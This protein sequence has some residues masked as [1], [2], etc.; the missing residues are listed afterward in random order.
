MV[1]A[2]QAIAGLILGR[3]LMR[4]HPPQPL[5]H[6]AAARYVREIRQIGASLTRQVAPWV[7]VGVWLLIWLIVAV[8]QS[9]YN[10]AIL[11]SI[12]VGFVPALILSLIFPL[13]ALTIA[14][15]R[16][17]KG[18]LR[19]I[20]EELERE[21]GR[22]LDLLSDPR[23]S[24]DHNSKVRD[25]QEVIRLTNTYFPVL[26]VGGVRLQAVAAGAV[27][28]VLGFWMG[29]ALDFTSIVSLAA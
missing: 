8:L 20:E 14:L 7:I 23:K 16:I 15:R 9:T 18:Q 3:E 25:L 5:S 28:Q 12:V 26:P 6:E 17:R 1:W 22:A 4:F 27:V 10:N 21:Y 11:Y 19:R 24:G 2:R 29:L 13:I